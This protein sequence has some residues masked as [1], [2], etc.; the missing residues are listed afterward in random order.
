MTGSE[1]GQ[2]DAICCKEWIADDKER[3]S[4]LLDERRKSCF[5]IT[6]IAGGEN[7]YLQRKLVGC[8]LNLFQLLFGI[9]IVSIH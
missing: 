5:E 1:T 3:S 9:G 4:T 2:L 6:F 7:D 8:D